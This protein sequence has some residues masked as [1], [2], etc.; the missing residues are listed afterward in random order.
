MAANRNFATALHVLTVLASYPDELVKSDYIAGSVNTNPAF[1]RR[2]IMS[3]TRAGMVDSLTGKNGGFR[4][5]QAPEHISLVDIYEAVCDNPALELPTR[6]VN[7]DCPMS[8]VMYKAL[9]PFL[10][11][12]EDAM[13]A[14]LGKRNL[15]EVLENVQAQDR[16]EECAAG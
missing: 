5:N 11:E 13:K 2:L 3:L 9:S 10:S 15:Q 6:P 16:D 12:A 7:K 14:A 8:C 1:I 4:L